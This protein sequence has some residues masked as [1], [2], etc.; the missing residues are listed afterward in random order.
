MQEDVGQN[1]AQPRFRTILLV[2]FAGLALVI[3][4]V[5]IYGVMAYATQQRSSEMAIR[6][7][8][9]SSAERI[10][11]LVVNDGL[12]LTGMGAVAG[13]L[14]GLLFGRYVKS[15]L[16]GIESTDAVTLGLALLMALVTGIA[17]SVLPARR[18]SRVG[19]AETLRH[20]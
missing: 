12:R 20:S 1:F 4:A 5:G 13:L 14:L 9:G 7:A 8:L 6:L 2:L 16:F 17:A 10:F 11:L 15:L 18:A 3:A 19:I